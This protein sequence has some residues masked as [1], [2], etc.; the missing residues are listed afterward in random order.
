MLWGN[1][2]IQACGVSEDVCVISR[3]LSITN[4]LSHGCISWKTWLNSFPQK[5]SILLRKTGKSHC[6]FCQKS[7]QNPLKLA[8]NRCHVWT[9]HA[10]NLFNNTLIDSTN[11]FKFFFDFFTFQLS[12]PFQEQTLY[13][14]FNSNSILE[15]LSALSAR[16][17]RNFC[18]ISKLMDH[19][20]GRLRLSLPAHK[21][22]VQLISFGFSDCR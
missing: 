1:I 20:N 18:A 21:I 11:E 2:I 3:R 19:E 10:E 7:R 13:R 16:K 5:L 9:V 17:Y 8:Q 12:A 22:L 14:R 6:M 15:V 4:T